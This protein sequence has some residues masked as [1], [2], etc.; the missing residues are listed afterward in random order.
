MATTKAAMAT[1][2][3]LLP[4]T[5]CFLLVLAAESKEDDNTV[6]VF[7][8][9]ARCK[10]NTS[11]IISNAPLQLVINNATIPGTG[12][13]TSTGQIVMAVSLTSAQHLDA[14][15]SNGSG[16]AFLVAPPHAC[17]APSIPPGMAVA[18]E[19]HPTDVVSAS[20]GLLRPMNNGGLHATTNAGGAATSHNKGAGDTVHAQMPA[21]AASDGLVLPDVQMV[22]AKVIDPFAC[23]L[24]G[25]FVIG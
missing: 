8:G 23:L 19:V 17:G 14:L 7:Y 5:L 25:F 12:R 16:K 18:V 11:R 24:L 9:T 4:V 3:M 6:V 10:I 1:S 22:L 2:K 20:G 13:T 15:T 21:I